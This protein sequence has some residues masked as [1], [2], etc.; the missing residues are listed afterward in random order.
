M[1]VI[2]DNGLNNLNYKIISKKNYNNI[3]SKIIHVIVDLLKKQDEINHTN[4]FPN[5]FTDNQVIQYKKNIKK[6]KW[7]IEYI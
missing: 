5:K 3:S 7:N 6:I 2:K 4:W 1:A